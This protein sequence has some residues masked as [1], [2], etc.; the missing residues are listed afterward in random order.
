MS[1]KN[2]AKWLKKPETSSASGVAAPKN[3]TKRWLVLGGC[4]MLAGVAASSFFGSGPQAPAAPKKKNSEFVDVSPKDAGE[5][6][7]QARSQTDIQALKDRLN[8]LETENKKLNNEVSDLTQTK[9]APS[10]VTQQAPGSVPPPP[11]QPGGV[12]PSTTGN[13]PASIP[14]PPKVL[15]PIT[16]PKGDLA[17]PPADL[18]SAPSQ[19]PQ[20]FKPEKKTSAAVSATANGVVDG[21]KATVQYKKNPN[22]GLLVAGAFAPIALLNGLDAG[23]AATAQSNPQPVLMQIQDNAILPGSAR[24][25]LKSCFALGSAY[26]DLS[27]ERVYV[28]LATLSC[29]DK[30]SRL[31]MTSKIQGYL[32]DSDGKLGLRGVVVDRQG[33]RLGKALLAGFASGLSNALGSAQGITSSNSLGVTTSLTGA[34]ALRSSGLSGASSAT[35]QLAQFYLKEAESIFPV[36]TVDTG[37]TATL[38]F[39]DSVA[40][41]WGEGDPAFTKDVT[42]QN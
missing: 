8:N 13:F 32:V 31:V 36:I 6:S 42:P 28:R 2:F 24:Y 7:W 23:T 27:A 9:P 15:E 1:D 29:V 12:A 11:V 20:V 17:L 37:R 10:T 35:S 3:S 30:A 19:E 16:P 33:A 5:K 21:V 38:V 4:L 39:S 22:S 18:Q 25:T 14:P 34:D 41:H 26:G 40:L